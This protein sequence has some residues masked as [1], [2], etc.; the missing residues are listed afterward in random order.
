[1]S[2]PLLPRVSRVRLT[3]YAPLFSEPI[4]FSLPDSPGPFVILGANTLGKTTIVQSTVFAIAGTA[5]ADVQDARE[6]KRFQWD[7]SY[8]RNRI[9]DPKS[10]EVRVDFNLGKRSLGVR[11]GLDSERIRGVR[12]DDADWVNSSEAPPCLK[13]PS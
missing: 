1:L 5:S 6:D 8:F 2:S 7:L 12:V 3:G 10:A 4:E 13:A 11:R 9:T